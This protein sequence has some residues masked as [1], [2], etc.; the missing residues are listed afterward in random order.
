[1]SI[2]PLRAGWD[3]LDELQRQMSRLFDF[4]LSSSRNLFQNWRQYPSCNLY[5][6]QGE[7]IFLIPLP[8]AKAEELEIT[9]MGNS[10][11]LKGERK[12]SQGDPQETYRREERW[13][14]KWSRTL[15]VPEKADMSQVAATMED[16]L[17]L[18]R[19]NKA[20]ESQPRQVV[21]KSN[22]QN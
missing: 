10:L 8:G 9:A 3:A 21:V 4:T 19:V 17:L 7:Y 14:G 22:H 1:M 15:Q 18:L 5:E 6:T 2:W 13:V 16:G 11:V 12:R 20:K